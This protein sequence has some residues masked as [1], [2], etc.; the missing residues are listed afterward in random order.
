MSEPHPYGIVIA[1]FRN[2]QG[3]LC[4]TCDGTEEHEHARLQCSRCG[5]QGLREN[6]PFHCCV[7]GEPTA[8]ESQG[9]T[10]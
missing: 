2:H 4:M 1:P 8:T 6:W 7:D 3:D 10:Q 5:K 9:E